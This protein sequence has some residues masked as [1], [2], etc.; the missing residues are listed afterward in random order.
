MLDHPIFNRTISELGALGTINGNLRIDDANLAGKWLFKRM[1]QSGLTLPTDRKWNVA[2]SD[3]NVIE[4]HFSECLKRV[5]SSAPSKY[6]ILATYF[7]LYLGV[8]DKYTPKCFEQRYGIE[9][10]LGGDGTLIETR[11]PIGNKARCVDFGYSGY[12]FFNTDYMGSS[13][14][15]AMLTLKE[16]HPGLITIL[17]LAKSRLNGDLDSPR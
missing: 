9:Q 14:F 7:L 17:D 2:Y 10:R 16:A 8:G 4:E 12:T 15:L 5:A 3:I 6:E 13:K 11:V 1:H